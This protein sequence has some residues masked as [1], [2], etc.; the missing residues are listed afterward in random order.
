MCAQALQEQGGRRAPRHARGLHG[1]ARPAVPRRLVWRA[2]EHGQGPVWKSTSASG[3]VRTRRKILISTQAGTWSSGMPRCASWRATAGGTTTS[4]SPRVWWS[5]RRLSRGSRWT[6]ATAR[7]TARAPSS[8]LGSDDSTRRQRAPTT[9]SACAA[10][11]AAATDVKL[12]LC[13][14]RTRYKQ[15]LFDFCARVRLP[16]RRRLAVVAELAHVLG[17]AVGTTHSIPVRK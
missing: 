15:G 16:P 9:P 17:V 14:L 2:Q 13:V 7:R 10:T 1:R 8:L 12:W 4:S 3:A 11:G 5:A 6:G